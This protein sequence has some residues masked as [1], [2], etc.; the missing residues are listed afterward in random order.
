MEPIAP[1][2]LCRE[3]PRY[4]EFLRHR[5]LAAMERGVEARNLRRLGGE[6]ADR[7][8]SSDMMRF[9]QRSEWY[10]S[11]EVGHDLAVD[12]HRLRI[13]H[14]AMDDT[15]P[16]AVESDFAA[17]MRREP[18]V[19]RCDA[20]GMAFTC[21]RPV[22]KLI[23]MR[24]VDLQVGRRPNAFD[25]AMSVRG[26]GPVGQ[27]LEYRELDAGRPGIDDEHWFAHGHHST[28]TAAARRAWA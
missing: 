12:Q 21:N 25:L 19:D 8:D 2:P 10:Q 22:G 4:C 3:L 1:N 23:A 26:K 6:G 16:H 28:L 5:R 15:V 20:A 14:P 7:T 24:I 18:I 17:D 9:M 11:F 13:S 27:S